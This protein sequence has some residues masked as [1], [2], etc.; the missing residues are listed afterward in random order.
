MTEEQDA[1]PSP[2]SEAPPPEKRAP[3]QRREDFQE[4]LTDLKAGSSKV[5]ESA[6]RRL[7]RYPE[8]AV[9]PLCTALDDRELQVRVAAVKALGRVGDERA[10]EPLVAALRAC[11]VGRSG[12]EQ[13]LN[14]LLVLGGGILLLPLYIPFYALSQLCDKPL[15][16][17]DCWE[18]PRVFVRG[19]QERRSQGR[20]CEAITQAV[21]QIAERHPT[22]ELR[23]VLPDLE[24][25]A[26]DIIQQEQSTR[27]KSRAAAAR[28]EALTEK[29]KSLPMPASAPEPD[30]D[31]LPRPAEAP[32]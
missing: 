17:H 29:A 24:A 5:R 2:P 27:Q 26:A 11:F 30:G 18:I 32:R 4:L 28:I 20:L 7:R 1:G 3:R 15:S 14:R 16:L 13:W 21:V 23:E 8:W 10:V 25:V 12:R 9:E 22:P 6:A 19:Y 31:T